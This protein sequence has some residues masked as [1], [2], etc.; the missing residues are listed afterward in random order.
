MAVAQGPSFQGP[1]CWWGGHKGRKG[2]RGQPIPHRPAGG[3]CDIARC[4]GDSWLC[5]GPRAW[6]GSAQQMFHE[7]RNTEATGGSG[8]T[9]AP[10]AGGQGAASFRQQGWAARGDGRACRG[11]PRGRAARPPPMNS[12]AHSAG[13]L[14]PGIQRSRSPC[15]WA[16]ADH[17]A[18]A[19]GPRS[20]SGV[21]AKAHVPDVGAPQG[22]RGAVPQRREGKPGGQSPCSPPGPSVPPLGPHW[23]LAG[24]WEK[25]SSSPHPRRPGVRCSNPRG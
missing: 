6:E 10:L 14:T 9:A 15:L 24:G 21:S 4:G 25:L 20:Q 1:G 16:S 8:A 11:G 3:I 22:D 17:G 5:R 2:P 13:A 18:R 7:D 19:R 23:A 12:P